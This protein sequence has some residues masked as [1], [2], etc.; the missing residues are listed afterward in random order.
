MTIPT[1]KPAE[2]PHE[3][4]PLDHRPAPEYIP[5]FWTGP[6]VGLRLVEA[7]RVLRRLPPVRGPRA[8]GNSWPAWLVE[9]EDQLAQLEQEQAERD[10]AERQQ[11]RVRVLPSSIE[12]TRMEIAIAW[13]GHYLHDCRQLLRTVSR[14]AFYRTRNHHIGYAARRMRLPFALARQWNREGLDII[15]QGLN[16]D[17]VRVF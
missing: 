4:H 6:H 9:W 15:A 7:L 16:R 11:N 10:L 5:P 14:V 8:F 12:I 3:W 17:A 2:L 1:A 13:L